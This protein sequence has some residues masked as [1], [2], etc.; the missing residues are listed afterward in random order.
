MNAPEIVRAD[1]L[2]SESQ[3]VTKKMELESKERII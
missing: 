2:T 3:L 1:D